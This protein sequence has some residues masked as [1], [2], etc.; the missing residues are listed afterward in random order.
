MKIANCLDYLFTR[1]EREMLLV[2][3][4]KGNGKDEILFA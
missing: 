2:V 3:K 4:K 1:Y